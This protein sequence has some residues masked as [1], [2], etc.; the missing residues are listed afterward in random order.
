MLM[1][2]S[3]ETDLVGRLKAEIGAEHVVDDVAVTAAFGRDITGRFAG[4]PRMVVRPAHTAATAAVLRVC[5]E[6]GAPVTVQGGNTGLSGGAVPTDGDVLMS[7]TRMNW[8][9]DVD[10]LTAQV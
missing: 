3:G 5:S 10:P 6:L 7:T 2:M 1:T 9:G 4:V 8:L